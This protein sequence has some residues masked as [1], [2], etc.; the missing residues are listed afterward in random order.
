MIAEEGG[1]GGGQQVERS[2][3]LVMPAGLCSEDLS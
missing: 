2:D 3:F 1:L